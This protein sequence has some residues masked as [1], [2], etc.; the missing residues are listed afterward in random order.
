MYLNG[1]LRRDTKEILT[2]APRVIRDAA[3]HAFL[4][5]KV[6]AERGN[7]AHVNPA[8]H[9]HAALAEGCERCGNYFSSRGE[10]NRGVE[11]FR[12]GIERSTGPSRAQLKRKLLVASVARRSIDLDVPVSRNL[13]GDVRRRAES[14]ESQ[15]PAFLDPREPQASKSNNSGAKQGRGLLIGKSL[16]NRVNKILRRNDVFRV[17]AIDGVSGERRTVAKIFFAPPAVFADAIRV[18]Q[19]SDTNS[20]AERI[21]PRTFSQTLND[22]DNLMPRDER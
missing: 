15:P 2:I 10:D 8:E 17:T 4:I 12:R 16:R 18:V 7:R 11:L 13:N 1:N 19:P 22:A 20:R 5:E 21:A 3:N 14:I 6:I 9:K